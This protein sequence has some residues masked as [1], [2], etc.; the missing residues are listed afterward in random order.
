MD[1]EKQVTGKESTALVP[2]GSSPPLPGRL[3]DPHPPTRQM[4]N[5]CRTSAAHL[6]P[7]RQRARGSRGGGGRTAE[8][9]KQQSEPAA[10]ITNNNT[11]SNTISPHSITRSNEDR[12][13]TYSTSP[14]L[15]T[16]RLALLFYSFLIIIITGF[17]FYIELPTK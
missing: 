9:H 5:I 3:L 11:Y 1:Q 7:Q 13:T 10:G 4:R 14:P 15:Y 12:F 17:Y 6:L 2:N 8:E 16:E